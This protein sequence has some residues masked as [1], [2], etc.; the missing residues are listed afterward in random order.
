MSSH[1][2]PLRADDHIIWQG[3]PAWLQFAQQVLHVRWVA[4][5][6]AVLLACCILAGA[7]QGGMSTALDSTMRF[8]GLALFAMAMLLGLAWGLCRTT[9]YS[10]TT[11]HLVI[12]Y[13]LAL[14]KTITIPYTKI[15]GA[16][17]R[18]YADGTGDIVLTLAQMKG[19]SY[20]L[21]WPHVRPW[22]MKRPEPMLR[23]VANGGRVANIVARVLANSADMAP[24]AMNQLEARPLLAGAA[25]AAA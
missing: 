10:L 14:A 18:A 16:S 17:Y 21:M 3:R 22:T 9:T 1:V 23:A 19:A 5:Y 2:P 25:T 6:V 8:G 24:V 15:T 20:P 4:A 13:G 12:E 11:T 7:Q